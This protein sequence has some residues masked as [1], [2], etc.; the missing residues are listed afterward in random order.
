MAAVTPVPAAVTP[1]SPAGTLRAAAERLRDTAGCNGYALNCDSSGLLH[2]V[3]LLLRARP[4]LA[5][6]LDG[7][8]RDAEEIGPDP[9]AVAVARAVLGE[10]EALDRLL[11]GEQR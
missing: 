6:W 2:M 10:T 1:A 5:D 11:G 7:A 4:L 8:A 3:A 9:Q